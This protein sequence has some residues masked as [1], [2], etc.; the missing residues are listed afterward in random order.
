[1]NCTTEEL[2]ALIRDGYF[3]V[4]VPDRAEL[5]SDIVV[6][7]NHY[8]DVR[9]AD[10]EDAM[11]QGGCMNAVEYLMEKC[12]ESPT[13]PSEEQAFIPL[14]GAPRFRGQDEES[15]S[16]NTESFDR[17]KSAAH[18]NSSSPLAEESFAQSPKPVNAKETKQLQ[19][20]REAV[21]KRRKKG[22]FVV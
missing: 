14:S 8:A 7:E 15:S 3:L 4:N 13:V 11:N 10:A 2:D 18:S 9:D 5:A 12:T 22:P 1:M 6:M 17:S 16:E 21:K 19:R 20:K